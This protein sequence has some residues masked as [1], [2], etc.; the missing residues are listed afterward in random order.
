MITLGMTYK[1]MYDHLA[2]DLDKLKYRLDYYKPKAIKEFRKARK[3]PA[4]KCYDYEFPQTRTKYVV[5]YYAENINCVDKPISGFFVDLLFDRKRLV[6]KWGASGYQ[7]TPECPLVLIRQLHAYSS[8]FLHRYNERFLK[9]DSLTANDIACQYLARNDIAMPIKI[10]EDINRNIDQYGEGG[11]QGFR[12]RDGLCFAQT[13]LEGKTS[14]DGDRTKDKVDAIA[15]VYTTFMTESLMT[16]G[17]KL[18]IEK[19]HWEKW[20]RAYLAFLKENNGNDI[21][22][23]LEP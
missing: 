22:L 20:T 6:V 13:I 21:V 9:D 8:H 10:T 14:E 11:K 1:Q 19:E 15:I 3:F 23:T 7:H 17:Q 16:K 12:V 4:W 5:Y 18:A 2:E